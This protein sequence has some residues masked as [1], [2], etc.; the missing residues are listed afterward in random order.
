MEKDM[1]IHS[2]ILAWRIPWMESG[3]TYR[4]NND[5]NNKEG[6][7]PEG[8]F[9][10]LAQEGGFLTQVLD[11]GIFIPQRLAATKGHRTIAGS[12]KKGGRE[13]GLEQEQ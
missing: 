12:S 4:L 11:V 7:A 2:S 9:Q 5:N 8:E 10:I 3:T 13:A 6:L 1:T